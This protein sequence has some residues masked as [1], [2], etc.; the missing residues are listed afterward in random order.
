MPAESVSA[1]LRKPGFEEEA[2]PWLDAV[3]RFALRLAAGRE[4]EA[5]DLTQET[6]LR[7]YRAWETFS[8][9]TNARAWLF[10]ICRNV[11]LRQQQVRARLPESTSSELDADLEALAAIDV[12]HGTAFNDPERNFFH[13][14]VDQ[15]VVRAIDALPV[16][17]REAVVLSDAEG[18]SYNDIATVLNIPKGT[19]KSRIFRGRRLL[20]QQLR[21]YALEMGYIRRRG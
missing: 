17:F 14:I 20:Q 7:A 9:G 3:Y 2:L 13:S 21:D 12:F 4:A 1:R 10:T 15:E 8:P 16:E 6:F 11:F 18:L 5:E 19:V